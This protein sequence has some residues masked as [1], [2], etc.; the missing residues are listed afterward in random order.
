MDSP[1]RARRV[2]KLMSGRW[3]A[4][5]ILLHY[6]KPVPYE[7]ALERARLGHTVFVTIEDADRLVQAINNEIVDR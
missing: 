6:N 5:P 1:I 3:V 4:Q 2:C 7:D